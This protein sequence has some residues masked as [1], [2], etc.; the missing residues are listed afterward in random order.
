MVKFDGFLTL[1]QEGHD[2][3][4][5]DEELR[6]LPAMSEDERL[7]KQ[8]IEASQH[9]TEPPPRF[10]EAALVKRM[11]ELGIGLPRLTP[12]FCKCCRTAAMCA[13]IRSG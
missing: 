11:E 12:R 13:S 3:A 8:A 5:E 10:S 2:E 9:F 1:Y 7:A 4:D 6:W